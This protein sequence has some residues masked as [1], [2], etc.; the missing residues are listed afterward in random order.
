MVFL[1]PPVSSLFYQL[2]NYLHL[3]TLVHTSKFTDRSLRGCTQPW[4]R[5][6]VLAV[7]S[8]W[9]ALF[10]RLLPGRF[11]LLLGSTQLLT[12]QLPLRNPLPAL[13]EPSPSTQGERMNFIP[14]TRL[15]Y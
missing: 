7:P 11:L 2:M 6:S 13:L 8:A 5:S 1:H 3:S 15:P 4:L 10:S 12:P 9:N 14:A